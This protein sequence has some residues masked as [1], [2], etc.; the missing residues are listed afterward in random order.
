[1]E[2]AKRATEPFENAERL[3][4][5]R[6]G[7]AP[8][9]RTLQLAEPRLRVR[10]LE[11]GEGPPLL[12][13]PG[14][15]AI[16]AAWAPLLAELPD[17]RTI[18]LD[19]PG[20]GLGE[21]FDYRRADLRRHA[22]TLL[23]SLLDALEIDSLPVA[24]SSG[25]AQWSLWLALHAPARVRALAVMGTPAVCLPGYTPTPSMRMASLPGV[26]RLLFALPSPSVKTTGKML[27][28]A[29][30]RI[31]DHPEILDAY[32]HAMRL[33]GYGATAS[34]IFRRSFRIGGAARREWVLTDTEL[35]RIT[36]PT[37]FAWGSR[38][39]F[40]DPDAA[41]RAAAVMPRA[42]VAIVPDAWHHPWLADAPAVGGMLRDFLG[43]QAP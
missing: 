41:H 34:A 3:V 33:P 8:R 10:V 1:M 4:F 35:A 14:D 20:F 7:I 37:L 29:D 18:V 43:E 11:C 30:V 12:L 36:Q 19:R 38:E 31:L 22:T 21:G 24:G 26:G 39:P 27:A 32:H 17:R 9:I 42:R 13:I 23:P 2:A 40:G 5:E 15:G 25:G 6:Y 28:R 16:A